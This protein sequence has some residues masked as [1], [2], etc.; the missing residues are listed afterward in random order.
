MTP[1]ATF[2]N[3]EP[4]SQFEA[5]QL[6]L[7]MRKLMKSLISGNVSTNFNLEKLINIVVNLTKAHMNS[8]P[9]DQKS[10]VQI[11]LGFNFMRSLFLEKVFE[12]N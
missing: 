1:W 6:K 5:T 2:E 7:I 8:I 3:K 4:I 11:D 12:N 9:K 10:K